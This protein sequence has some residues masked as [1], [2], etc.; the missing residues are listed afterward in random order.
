MDSWKLCFFT[1]QNLGGKWLKQSHL[2]ECE[3]NTV[4]I[5]TVYNPE[6]STNKFHNFFVIKSQ[7]STAKEKEK[8]T[9]GGRQPVSFLL[10]LQ[11]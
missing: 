6:L 11:G 1:F 5:Q 10:P 4:F 7:I 8:V 2:C 9:L 3:M